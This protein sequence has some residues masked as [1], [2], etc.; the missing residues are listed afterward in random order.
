MD[1]NRALVIGN[2]DGIG[3]GLTKR[4]LS[5][6][7]R[8]QGVSRSSSSVMHD[9]YQHLVADVTQDDYAE[10][11]R[12]AL[13]PAPA[14]VVYCA[15]IGEEFNEATLE[16]DQ[17]VFQV[18]LM[19]AVKT[20][21]IA[22]PSLIRAKQGQIIVLS[23]LG[24]KVVAK[25]APSYYA[26]KAGLSSYIEGIAWA[27]RERGV[28]VTNVRFGFVDTKMAK[29]DTKPQMMSVDR[30]VEH[31]MKCVRIRPIRYS[32]PR[33]MAALVT[34]AGCLMRVKSSLARVKPAGS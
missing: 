29:G 33:F 1:N 17:K 19:G 30:A 23:S 15:G 34:I 28:A 18:N 6:G 16:I 24:D 11:L 2:S 26:S 13:D 21:E 25:E 32:R 27:V 12:R 7:W 3:L 31:L 22:L 10:R 8:V 9:T 14:L 20:I 4:L 5:D